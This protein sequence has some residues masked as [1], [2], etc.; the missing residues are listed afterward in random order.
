[1]TSHLRAFAAAAGIATLLAGPAAAHPAATRAGVGIAQP[2]AFSRPL[3]K[4]HNPARHPHGRQSLTRSGGDVRAR[5]Y[6]M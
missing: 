2:V 5:F 4:K 3:T 1:M 6:R